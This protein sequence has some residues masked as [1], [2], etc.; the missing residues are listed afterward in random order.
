[1]NLIDESNNS[2]NSMKK[3]FI[4]CGAGAFILLCV[5]IFL[6][7]YLTQMKD[8]NIDLT[9]NNQKVNYSNYLIIQNDKYYI[10]IEDL[11]K[12]N[13]M[14]YS[15]KSG[16]KEVEDTNK[17]YVTDS[18]ESTF[19]E[20]G[21]NR[22]YKVLT[23]TEETEFYEIE[24]V[25]IKEN[26][27]IY[28]PLSA[29][30]V[31]FNSSLSNN[32]NKISIYSMSYI[33]GIYNREKKDNFVPDSSIVWGTVYSNK[34]LLKK[35]LVIVKDSTGNL[36]VAKVSSNTETNG[37]VKVTKVSTEHVITPKYTSI[38]YVEEFDQ[39]IVQN[40]SGKGVVQLEEKEDGTISVKTKV[41]PQFE[42]IEPINSELFL[43]SKTV[44][45]KTVKYGIVG[46]SGEVKLA[47][48]YDKIGVD[49]LKFTNNNL[50]SEF[51]IYDNLIPV[52]KSGLWG[53][54]N[55]NGKIVIKTEYQDFG[56]DTSNSTSNVLIV[57]EQK[58]IVVKKNDKYEI[59]TA[60]KSVLID[61]KIT[62]IYKENI[63]G[64]D[65]YIM[66]Y[67]GKKLNVLD[68]INKNKT[69]TNTNT[70]TTNKNNAPANTTN[71][72]NKNNAPA[73]TTN[74]T[75]KNNA[76]ANNTQ[77]QNKNATTTNNTEN[78]KN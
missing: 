18:Y 65:E 60:S 8:T 9:I 48:E 57:P 46:E 4:I 71:T 23:G 14:G 19:F 50:T 49:V 37:K 52:K 17:C 7:V 32:N 72:T 24:D 36:G 12:T 78:K 5:I 2:N 10:S 74:T 16:S 44:D 64:K 69:K 41:I 51:I 70:N 56:C 43:V 28:M 31:A 15:Y 59:I 42:N 75:N 62:K 39:L 63:D 30:E 27:K 61:N 53:M 11:A 47:I 76:P 1:M 77:T 13:G 58:G 45:E 26:E 22:I 3:I 25:V 73:N 34:K 54:I 29:T 40:E 33:E 55:L 68:T 20:V 21:S 6:L 66:I 38:E 35:G 67:D